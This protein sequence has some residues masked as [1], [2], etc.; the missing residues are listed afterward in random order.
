MKTTHPLR[1]IAL[2]AMVSG[3]IAVA[4]LE[5]AD[6]TAA[7]RPNPAC[8]DMYPCYTWCPGEPLP[9]SNAPVHWDMSVCHDW[10]YGGGPSRPVLEGTPPPRP[11]PPLWV[12]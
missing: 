9:N 10:Y 3:G 12:P 5:V 1:R 2:A 4:A 6:G 11:I 8:N 7:A